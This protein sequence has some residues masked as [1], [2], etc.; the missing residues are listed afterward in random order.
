MG[1]NSKA[2]K[3]FFAFQKSYLCH[4]KVKP[5]ETFVISPT[6][7]PQVLNE[8]TLIEQ[9]KQ[10]DEAAFK[11]IVESSR[12]LVYNTAL[13]IVQNPEDAEDVSQEVFVQL[14]ESIHTFKGESKLS[15]WLYRI[16]ISKAMDH[17]RKKKRKKRF[18]FVQSIFGA[19]DELVHD[20]PDF[21]HPGVS[22]DNKEK[23]AELFKA[24]AQLPEKQKIAFT[25][26]R[27]EGLSYQEISEIMKLTVASVESLLHRARKNLRKLLEAYYLENGR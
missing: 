14:Y 22:L 17:L 3:R 2:A 26:N 4:C 1:C 18:A 6:A 9:L 20:P 27:L 7:I 25:L 10:G 16:T 21:V 15:T 23:A 19:N 8:W 24:I 5:S 12:G 13:G 11:Q